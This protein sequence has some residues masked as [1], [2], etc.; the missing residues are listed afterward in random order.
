MPA[1]PTLRRVGEQQVGAE[2]R[3][4][5][6]LRV[7]PLLRI[8]GE[9]GSADVQESDQLEAL[10]KRLLFG[11]EHRE[12]ICFVRQGVTQVEEER[13]EGHCRTLRAEDAAE[14]R[15]ALCEEEGGGGLV[16]G[17]C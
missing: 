1:T 3:D 2:R 15:V 12:T 16:R 9:R 4:V 11:R 7:V 14:D 13:E 8:A 10:Q 6:V 5:E 17:S